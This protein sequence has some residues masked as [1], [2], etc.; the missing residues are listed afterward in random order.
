MTYPM[1]YLKRLGKRKKNVKNVK[2]DVNGKII[3]IY[4]YIYVYDFVHI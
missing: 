3:Y 2:E 1:T 4:I